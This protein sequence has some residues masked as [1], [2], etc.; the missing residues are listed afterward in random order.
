M[1]RLDAHL[2]QGEIP[3]PVSHR[4]GLV[5]QQH[6]MQP[7]ELLI[8]LQIARTLAAPVETVQK[9]IL[10]AALVLHAP[11]HPADGNVA[12]EQQV[13]DQHQGSSWDSGITSK[14]PACL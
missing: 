1:N 3:Y 6:G 10:A 13:G 11:D 12:V 4:P 5:V 2:S 9:A 8:R 7:L 14:A